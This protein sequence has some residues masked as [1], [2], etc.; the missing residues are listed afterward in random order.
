MKKQKCL[1]SIEISAETI[2]N[3]GNVL[4]RKRREDAFSENQPDPQKISSNYGGITPTQQTASSV[5]L[6]TGTLYKK[7][8]SLLNPGT[9]LCVK[10]PEYSNRLQGFNTL[11]GLLTGKLIYC[12]Q[13]WMRIS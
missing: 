6:D 9:E 5:F 1:W 2:S 7:S 8:V 4:K 12:I 11:G 13:I 3:M 10:K